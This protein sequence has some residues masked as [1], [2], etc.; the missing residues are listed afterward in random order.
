MMPRTGSGFCQLLVR[1]DSHHGHSCQ[2]HLLEVGTRFWARH[3]TQ[4]ARLEMEVY[5]GPAWAAG[6]NKV[7]ESRAWGRGSGFPAGA[8]QEPEPDTM[9]RFPFPRL[10]TLILSLPVLVHTS[11]C[12]LF[13][14]HTYIYL[15]LSV[16]IIVY[17]L[18]ECGHTCAIL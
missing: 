9:T 2:A 11:V 1:D 16:I 18:C 10:L 3:H 7:S 12:L 17:L 4:R 6:L 14:L 5:M 8:F 15:F 13:L